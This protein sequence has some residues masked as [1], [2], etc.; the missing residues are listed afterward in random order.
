MGDKS[1]IDHMNTS[2]AQSSKMTAGASTESVPTEV[3]VKSDHTHGSDHQNPGLNNVTQSPG[4]SG[5]SVVGSPGSD[6]VHDLPLELLQMGWRRFWSRRES[7]PY[8]FNKIT[9]ESLWDMPQ[10]GNNGTVS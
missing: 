6:P 1:A 9:N 5:S 2:L 7:R 3:K 4:S 10:I 8:F